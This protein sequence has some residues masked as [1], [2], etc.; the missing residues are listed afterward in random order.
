MTNAKE[1]RTNANDCERK[2]KAAGE[3]KAKKAY[4]RTAQIWRELAD[5][6]ETLERIEHPEKF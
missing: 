1:C 3:L 4:A 5:Q 6:L 2:A